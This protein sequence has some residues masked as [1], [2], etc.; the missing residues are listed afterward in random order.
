MIKLL[1]QRSC[2]PCS[3]CRVDTHIVLQVGERLIPVCRGCSFDLHHVLSQSQIGHES[4]N[5]TAGELEPTQG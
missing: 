1:I 2:R 5:A 4:S 3:E